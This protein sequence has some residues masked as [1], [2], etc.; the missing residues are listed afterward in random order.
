MRFRMRHPTLRAVVDDCLS[1]TSVARRG[2]LRPEAVQQVISQFYDGRRLHPNTGQ[3]WQRLWLLVV[4]EL[5][6]R[7]HLDQTG[8]VPAPCRSEET[9]V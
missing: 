3:L 2:L 5:W 1:P 8:A 7:Q 9:A 4:L 6:L